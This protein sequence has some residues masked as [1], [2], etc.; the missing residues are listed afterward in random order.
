MMEKYSGISKRAFPQ[1]SYRPDYA[2]ADDSDDLQTDIEDTL[3]LNESKLDTLKSSVRDSSPE[4]AWEATELLAISLQ[5][6]FLKHGYP[7]GVARLLSIFLVVI[8]LPRDTFTPEFLA[9][10]LNISDR[11]SQKARKA[12]KE[13][14]VQRAKS[15]VEDLSHFMAIVTTQLL[16]EV[17]K[18]DVPHY[19]NYVMQ[20]YSGGYPVMQAIQKARQDVPSIIRDMKR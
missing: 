9:R 4:D 7:Q 15:S 5:D 2:S 12:I 6:V 13:R 8:S 11:I 20:L 14:A 10:K 19:L 18:D 1:L 16:N 17:R 3:I